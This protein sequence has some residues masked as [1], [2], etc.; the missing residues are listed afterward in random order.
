MKTIKSECS[1]FLAAVSKADERFFLILFTLYVLIYFIIHTAWIGDYVP[2]VDMVQYSLL[3]IVMWG[4]GLYLFFIIAAWK[5][6]FKKTVP[7]V[8]TG[9]I[10]L[11]S[12]YFFTKNMST[13]LYGAVMDAVFCILAC[14]KYFK[15]M[16]KCIFGVSILY[17]LFAF[18]SMYVGIT[19]DLGKPNTDFPGHSLGID[20]PNTWGYLMFLAL[21]CAW[22][23]YLKHK[24]VLTYA[25]F[26][27]IS[28]FMYQYIRCRTI[29]GLAI[30]Y[31]VIGMIVYFIEKRA[32]RNAAETKRAAEAYVF[33]GRK[34]YKSRKASPLKGLIIT[35]PFISWAIMMINSFNVEWWYQFY[36]GSLRNLAWRFIQGGLYFRTYGIP[37]IGNPYRSNEFTYVNVKGEFIQ[38]GIL[39]SSFASYIIMRGVLWL[40]VALV[41]L[42]IAYWKALKKRDFAI[43]LIETVLLGFAMMERPGLEMWYNFVLLYPFAKVVNKAGTESVLEFGEKDD[44]GSDGNISEITAYTDRNCSEENNEVENK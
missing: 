29:A 25:V 15:K 37:L 19:A 27:P 22:Y 10:I 21:I 24:P 32:D 18:I 23:L 35:I 40:L 41:W 5:N 26:W 14:G 13:N 42:C 28:V 31:P 6:L 39:D 12:I 44:R 16:V 30:V 1:S 36:H 17:L 7:L 33:E 20:Y 8:L 3:S 11:L 4:T 38:V 9:F 43:I 34:V 2:I